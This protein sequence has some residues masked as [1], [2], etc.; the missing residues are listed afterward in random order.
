MLVRSVGGVIV[1]AV[2]VTTGELVAA[3]V[4]PAASPLLAVGQAAIDASPEW[5]KSF[6]IGTFGA[7]D[8]RVLVAG[9]LVLLALASAEI[10]MRAFDRPRAGYVA[11]AILG[12]V[13]VACALSRSSAGAVWALPSIAAAAAGYAAFGLLRRA[14]APAREVASSPVGSPGGEVRSVPTGFDRRRFLQAALALSAVAVATNGIA[15]FAMRRRIAA[16]SRSMVRLPPPS[17]PAR[18]LPAGAKLRVP[19]VSP[20]FTP[21]DE[22]YRVDTTLFVPQLRVQDWR[23]RIHG[24]VDRELE[25]GFE[26][27]IARP[28]IERD[29]TLNCVS[30]PVGG[31][32]VGNAR[33]IG[34]ALKPLLD[35]AGAHPSATQIASTSSDGMTIGTPTAVALDGRDAM[36][37]VAMNGQPLPFEHGFPVR[38]LVP[39]L[40]GYESA[41]KWIVDIELTTLEAFH[42]Y[43]VQR[44]WAQVAGLQTAS[45]IDT[46]DR[47]ARVAAGPVTVAGVAWAQHRGIDRV[48]VSVDGGAWN[49]ATLSAED[50]IDTWRQWTWRWNA[51]AGDHVLSVR[52]T[53][54]NGDVQPGMHAPPFPSGSRGWDEV[55]VSAS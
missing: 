15:D 34:A 19:G 38:M 1:A 49:E 45:R 29:I 12:G 23:L 25:I 24:M 42:A 14:I 28:L 5:L 9:I 33:W 32:Y 55:D 26:E 6:A 21:N 36:L 10:G 47:G 16:V 46:P 40:Y 44:G 8:K 22:F 2:A 7:D 18:P 50:S 51:T 52:A 11:L 54:G 31:R 53:D 43:W 48:E 30:N 20:F 41:T 13:G 37:A 17:S 39:G 4:A 27:L 3:I 35:E